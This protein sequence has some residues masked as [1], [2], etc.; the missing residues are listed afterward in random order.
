MITSGTMY[1][2][3]SRILALFANI[4]HWGFI[5]RIACLLIYI[6]AMIMFPGCSANTWLG[7]HNVFNRLVPLGQTCK[8]SIQD[9]SSHAYYMYMLYIKSVRCIYQRK[10]TVF[11][12]IDLQVWL[13]HE[14]LL[15]SA[16]FG[17][18]LTR[19]LERPTTMSQA[20][21]LNVFMVCVI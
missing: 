14:E 21:V 9:I 20:Y 17:R 11:L 7:V 10:L 8:S 13:P 3:I 16:E 18:L 4:R 6:T 2:V 12:K 19:T 5:A 15:G 1:R